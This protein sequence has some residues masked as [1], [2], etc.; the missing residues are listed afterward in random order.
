MEHDELAQYLDSLKRED[1]YRVDGVLKE[2]AHE[3]TQRVFFVG[4]NGAESGPYIRK[5]IQQGLGLGSVYQRVYEAQRNGRRF[6]HIP[7]VLECY[8]RDDHLVV[9]VEFIH[10]D[11]LQEAVYQNDPSLDLAV[12]VFPQICDAVS[13]LHTEFDPSII[14]RDLKPS[15]IVL[16]GQGL[17]LIDFGISREYREQADSDT[18]H[19]GT[20]EFAPPE[21]FGFGQT[22]VYSDVYSLGMVLYY[23]LTEQIPSPQA[24]KEGFADPGIPERVRVVIEKAC[25]LDPDM[26]YAS[27]ADLKGA[28]LDAVQPP[29]QQRGPQDPIAQEGPASSREKGAS[30]KRIALGVAAV[31][32]V[33]AVGIGVYVGASGT[34]QTASAPASSQSNEASGAE[35]RGS[36]SENT[37]GDALSESDIVS[38]LEIS[39][40]PKDGFDPL[41]N[42]TVNVAGVEFQMPSCFKFKAS[43]SKDGKNYYYAESGSSVVMVMTFERALDSNAGY[44]EDELPRLKDEFVAGVMTSGSPF[45]EVASSTDCELA[46]YAA[47][48]VT[49][50]GS[51]EGLPVKTKMALFLNPETSQI[52][53][54]MCGQ[55]TNAQFDYSGDFAKIITSASPAS[56]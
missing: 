11:T 20:R 49:F 3:T 32:C 29:Q 22:G 47:R 16:T 15:N 41:T 52:G 33:I 51:V 50:R 21:Q 17:A 7:N 2:S 35:A 9:V 13:E 36:S 24:R 43:A 42:Y 54:V 40:K 38:G 48:I 27:A 46:G 18:A 10:G 37:G 8:A 19:F 53:C 12:R 14:H 23:C 4:E 25:A 34:G 44:A 5:F 56:A 31:A 39:E 55:T 45:D 28:F 6:K 30:G 26:R 1:C